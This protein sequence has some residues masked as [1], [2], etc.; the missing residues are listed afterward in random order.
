MIVDS[1]ES[2]YKQVLPDHCNSCRTC[3]MRFELSSVLLTIAAL[4]SAQ[5]P[6]GFNPSVSAHLDVVFGSKSVSPP[7]LTLTKA[8]VSFLDML[9]FLY[10][11]DYISRYGQ[12]THN[13]YYCS[14][15]CYLYLFHDR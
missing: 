7:G 2:R 6:D 9:V 11:N 15:E 10:P 5:T 4:A 1:T 3:T 13:W 12:T 8:G 14:I